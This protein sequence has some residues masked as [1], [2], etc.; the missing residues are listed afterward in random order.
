MTIQCGTVP[1]SSI[2]A[3]EVSIVHR[4]IAT[5]YLGAPFYIPGKNGGLQKASLSWQMLQT[6]VVLNQFEGA[7]ASFSPV[8]TPTWCLQ[9]AQ[10]P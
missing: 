4:Y 5:Y 7:G 1:R 9:A 6:P 10:V 8:A 3:Y 2:A